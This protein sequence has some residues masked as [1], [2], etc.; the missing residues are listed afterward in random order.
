M[1]TD[2]NPLNVEIRQKGLKV[3]HLGVGVGDGLQKKNSNFD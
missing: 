1:G 3:V 2:F